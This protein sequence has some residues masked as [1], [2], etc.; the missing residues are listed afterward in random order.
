MGTPT[1]RYSSGDQPVPKPARSRPPLI[2]SMPASCRASRAGGYQ[3]ALTTLLP[4]STRS[5]ATAAAVRTV[6]GSAARRNSSGTP[7]VPG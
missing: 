2:R 4:S 7:S 3:G 1:A 5:V 6:N